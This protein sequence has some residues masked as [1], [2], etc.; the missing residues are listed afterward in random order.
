MSCP[1]ISFCFYSPLHV[2]RVPKIVINYRTHHPLSLG[3]S[4]LL[5]AI[6]AWQG[7][8]TKNDDVI[9]VTRASRSSLARA[10]DCISHSQGFSYYHIHRSGNG[11]EIVLKSPFRC[12]SLSKWL[13]ELPRTYGQYFPPLS[14]SCHLSSTQS[15]RSRQQ[16]SSSGHRPGALGVIEQCLSNALK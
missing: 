6:L 1:L 13:P 11:F 14:K 4:S 2:P 10:P 8:G 9:N 3:V 7:A 16:K 15:M 12:S 5:A